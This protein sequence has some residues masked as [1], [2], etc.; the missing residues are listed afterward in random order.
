[1]C[2]NDYNNSFCIREHSICS[3]KDKMVVNNCQY[4]IFSNNILICCQPT[5][6]EINAI[7]IDLLH[8]Y[9]CKLLKHFFSN[10]IGKL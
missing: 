5:C 2:V 1:M 7:S 6:A 4:E 3:F 9:S 10:E 8:K